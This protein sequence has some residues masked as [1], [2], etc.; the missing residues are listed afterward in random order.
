VSQTIAEDFAGYAIVT[1]TR[2]G[3]AI[4]VALTEICSAYARR[5]V[6]LELGRIVII[7]Q[8][9]KAANPR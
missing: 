1:E 5:K 4:E 8:A 7:S 9:K 3:D 2:Q 6:V